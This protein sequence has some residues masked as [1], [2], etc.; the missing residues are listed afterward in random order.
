[1]KTILIADDDAYVTRVL[2]LA[3]EN[4]G[5]SVVLASTGIQALEKIRNSVPDCL[6][7]DINMPGMSGRELVEKIDEEF[8]VRKFPIL[9]VSSL[10]SRDL[11]EWVEG[12]V[13]V[14][15]MEKPVSPKSLVSL[16]ESALS[17]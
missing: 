6:V 11:K 9:I 10:V 17:S 3:L 8:K 5:F 16:V 12:R 1:M 7:T 4:H 15:F 14:V 13:G 2:R